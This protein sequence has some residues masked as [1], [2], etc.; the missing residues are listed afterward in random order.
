M[1]D[2]VMRSSARQTSPGEKPAGTAR[3]LPGRVAQ[4]TDSAGPLPGGK[5]APL[6]VDTRAFFEP[7]FGTDFSDVRV[8]RGSEADASAASVQA[9]AYTFG[10]NVVFAH[11]EYAPGSTDG[12]RLLA[13]ELGH[14]VQQRKGAIQQV[15]RTPASQV[16]CAPGPLH[17]PGPPPLDIADPV[18]VIT[19]AENTAGQLMDNLIGELDFTRNRIIGGAPVGWPTISDGLAF[20]VRLMGL[21]P[22][23]AG[24]WTAPTGTGQRSV[25]LLLRRLRLIRGTIGAGTFFFT[26]L[27]PDNG[28]VGHCV[29]PICAGGNFVVSCPGEF[30]MVFCEPFWRG[31]PEDQSARII[32]ESAHNFADFVGHAGRFANAECFARAAQMFGGVDAALQRTDLCPDP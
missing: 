22:D 25:T 18:G 17:V 21:D 8:H 29:G 26:C 4:S 10:S 27:G 11:G 19:T 1:A 12:R 14:V 23:D 3:P 6:D 30:Q 13:H 31:T 2:T 32:H 15:Q 28:A 9:R 20:S 5:G 7:R 16:S 24:V